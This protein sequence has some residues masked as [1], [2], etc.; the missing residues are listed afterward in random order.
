M[1]KKNSCVPGFVSKLWTLVD[2]P[3]T[4]D[5]ICWSLDGTNF[6]ILDE[7][8]FTKEILPKYFK[9]S[10]L[11][12]FVRQLNMYGFRKVISI[13]G[14]LVKP[15]NLSV[16]EFHHMHFQKG[17]E[18]LLD[19]I[20]RKVS[21]VRTEDTKISQEDMCKVLEDVQQ[22][23]GKQEDMDQKLENMKSPPI[24][25]GSH[26]GV[27]CT[28][29][30]PSLKETGSANLDVEILDSILQE[31]GTAMAPY[32]KEV[33][34]NRND[35][36]DHI[37]D[38]DSTFD[39]L[40]TL[41]LGRHFSVKPEFIDNLFN[42]GLSDEEVDMPENSMNI[43]M[44]SEWPCSTV[45][46]REPAISTEGGK[47]SGGEVVQRAP[48][49]VLALL[50]ELCSTLESDRDCTEDASLLSVK[51]LPSMLL[52][53]SATDELTSS[54]LTG[55]EECLVQQTSK[56]TGTV[57]LSAVLPEEF[58]VTDNDTTL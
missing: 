22:V 43:G 30:A 35:I 7:Q 20:K 26:T 57:D 25:E 40:Q 41:L 4:N 42:P 46:V 36:Q 50:D 5:V 18:D 23:R 54:D 14:G 28:A 15:K 51:E 9:H 19:C 24:L 45:Q 52:P 13:E 8:R 47:G 48:N 3:G 56:A 33:S 29:P 31:D 16:L 11:S 6:R 53:L 27:T 49:H 12:S 34:V 55:E 39:D 37:D 1:M 10:N 58:C 38:I 2:N 21:S 44:V 17:R 32:Q